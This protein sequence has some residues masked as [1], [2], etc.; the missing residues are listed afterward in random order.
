M[1]TAVNMHEY[2]V[3]WCGL[4]ALVQYPDE[5]TAE[6]AKDYLDGHCMYPNSR[7]KVGGAAANS[8]P[9]Y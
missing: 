4:Q 7:N 2:V 3:P 8:C 9:G 6:Q 1:R 5:A